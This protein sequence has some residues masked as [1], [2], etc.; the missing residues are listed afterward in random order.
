MGG[1]HEVCEVLHDTQLHHVAEV[2]ILIICAAWRRYSSHMLLQCRLR[3]AGC[4]E[5]PT[6]L[7]KGARQHCSDMCKPSCY[8]ALVGRLDKCLLFVLVA[9]DTSFR[10]LLTS[11]ADVLLVCGVGQQEYKGQDWSSR[12]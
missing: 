4:R 8:N 11:I 5:C 7:P 9:T 12:L 10:G 2:N 3:W 6:H 1:S